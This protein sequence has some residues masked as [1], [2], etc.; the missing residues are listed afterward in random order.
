MSSNKF[1]KSLN[2]IPMILDNS[3]DI[4]DSFNMIL[5][6]LKQTFDYNFAFIAYINSNRVN[7]K[8]VKSSV[9]INIEENDFF[10]ISE[11]TRRELFSPE[12]AYVER[13]STLAKGLTLDKYK[14]K[15][16]ISK[17]IIRNTV[18]GFIVIAKDLDKNFDTED[19]DILKSVSSI[20]S[21]VIKDSEL[22][23]VFKMQLKSLQDAIIEKSEAN[24]IIQEQNEKILSADKVKNEFL[25]NI[26]HELRTP[27][28]SII[29]FA[30]ILDNGF[31][32]QLNEKQKK[33]VSDIQAS[34]IHLLGMINEIL[35][36]S[37]IEA[38]AMK[39]NVMEFDLIQNLSEV[40]NIVKP[41]LNK[42]NLSF[43]TNFEEKCF[44]QADYQKFQQIFYNLLSNAIK[45]TEENGK[46]EIGFKTDNKKVTI[47]VK[48]NGIGIAKKYHGKIFGKFVQLGN[49]LTKTGSSTGLGLT[50]TKELVQLHNGKISLESVVDKGT[51]FFVEMPL[52]FKPKKRKSIV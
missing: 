49:T 46:V 52:K 48:D 5:D 19:K 34:G 43:T 35:D 3:L 50:I 27:L 18:F 40:S 12:T 29:G 41:L 39:L 44:I 15:Y 1:E 2:S 38:K 24:R 33:Y 25:A 51:T 28:T 31:Y 36:I 9:K 47:W 8:K 11:D 30:E 10:D 37:K 21:Y 32:G 7:I 13:T 14:S 17:L 42:K 23:G 6:M 4:D 26:S 22:S 45:Y 16:L 20:C